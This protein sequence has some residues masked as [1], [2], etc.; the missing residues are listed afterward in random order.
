MRVLWFSNTPCSAVAK[1]G[2]N[3]NS[4]G[5]LRPLE[6]ELK[7]EPE[8][9]LAICFYTYQKLEPFYFN[10]TQ[11]YPVLR[12]GKKSKLNR[13]IRRFYFFGVNDDFEINELIKVIDLFKPEIIHVHGTEDNFGLV[14]FY[15]NIP[16]VI[17]IQGIISSITEKYFSGIPYRIAVCHENIFN[18]LA[19]AG[20]SHNFRQLEKNAERERKST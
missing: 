1:L 13:Y 3:L 7:K 15:T 8:I 19:L 11:F 20:I 18:K 2:I 14:Q 6:N 9:E 5:W 17:S 4:G 16:V 10:S 12:Q